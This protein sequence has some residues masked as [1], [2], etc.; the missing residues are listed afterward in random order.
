MSINFVTLW[1]RAGFSLLWALNFSSPRL[2]PSQPIGKSS[3]A[4]EGRGSAI[5]YGPFKNR[6]RF[7][8]GA[9]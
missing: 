1:S 5:F 3:T 6:A 8:F 7:T 9:K 4:L 2:Q